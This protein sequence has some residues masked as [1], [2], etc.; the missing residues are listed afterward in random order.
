M[1]GIDSRL[2]GAALLPEAGADAS[3]DLAAAQTALAAL[4]QEQTTLTAR[5]EVLARRALKLTAV[6]QEAAATLTRT[7][8]LLDR[9]AAAAYKGAAD[10]LLALLP[11]RDMLTLARR[12]KLAGQAG[13]SLR[14]ISRAATNARRR[15]GKSAEKTAIEMSHVQERLTALGREIPAADRVVQSR[16]A[17]A[18]SDLP[19][20]KLA[21]SGIPVAAMDAYLRAARIVSVTTPACGLEWWILAGIADGESGHGTHGGAR[22]DVNGNVFPAIVGIPL[23]GTNGTQAIAD[24]DGGLY[25]ADPIWDH[26]V[27]VLQFIPSTWN[28]WASDGNLDGVTDPQNLYDAALGA[29]NKLCGDAGPEGM[30]TDAQIARALK[31]YAVTAA[32]VKAKLTRAREY[33]AQGLPTP[34]ATVAAAI[35]AG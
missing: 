26:A 9:V 13:T 32:L 11:S 22:A 31:P 18:A 24:T 8:A 25:D 16:T 30:H 19:A 3:A 10:D 17:Q 7:Q 27:G 33:E 5:A 20:R 29:A 2:L 14:E 21:L 6:Q 23:D 28:H 15:A 4:V 35:P 12:M 34:D 1:P